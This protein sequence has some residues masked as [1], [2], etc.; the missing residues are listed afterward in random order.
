MLAKM[1]LGPAAM[2]LLEAICLRY[3]REIFSFTTI[4]PIENNKII[5]ISH[6]GY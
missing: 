4:L 5:D 6:A 2:S 1:S 3:S